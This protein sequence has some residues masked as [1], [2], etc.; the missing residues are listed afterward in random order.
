MHESFIIHFYLFD[1]CIHHSQYLELKSERLLFHKLDNLIDLKFFDVPMIIDSV[2][3]GSCHFFHSVKYQFD[4][5][6]SKNLT[7]IL[8]KSHATVTHPYQSSSKSNPNLI[9]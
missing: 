1:E 3:L 9:R 2:R 5:S 6:F 8:N 7:L 4:K